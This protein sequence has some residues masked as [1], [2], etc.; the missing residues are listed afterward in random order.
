[1]PEVKDLQ[2]GL[3][4]E[5]NGMDNQILKLPLYIGET[6]GINIGDFPIPFRTPTL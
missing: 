6:S 5:Y 2:S 3:L 1:M 4:E